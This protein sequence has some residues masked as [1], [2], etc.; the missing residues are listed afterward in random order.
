M[1]NLPTIII[2]LA[3]I[4]V[5]IWWYQQSSIQVVQISPAVGGPV[6]EM[7]ERIKKI[8]IDT[9]FFSD[10]QFLGFSESPDLD[11]AGLTT[12]RPNP[13]LSLKK[14]AAGIPPKR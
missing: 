8:H 7:V 4:G 12:G 10:Q 9:A 14:A 1:K 5:G 6:L 3:I 2:I 13:F 11:V